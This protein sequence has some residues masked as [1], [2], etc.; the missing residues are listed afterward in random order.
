MSLVL[1]L[2]V[3]GSAPSCRGD[4]DHFATLADRSGAAV[5]ALTPA[6]GD[7]RSSWSGEAATAAD[8]RLLAVRDGLAAL[9]SSA[10]QARD[11]LRTFADQLD[12]VVDRMASVRARAV[13]AGL[14]VS[15]A[16][17]RLPSAPPD[18][19]PATSLLRFET[20]TGVFADLVDD[21][22]DARA[23]EL[24]AHAALVSSLESAT[25]DGAL[26]RLLQGAGL[27]P[28]DGSPAALAAFGL[29]GGLL[30]LGWG[31]AWSTS[32]TNGRFLPTGR[33]A[34]LNGYES[35]WFRPLWMGGNAIRAANP[36]NWVPAASSSSAFTQWR[37]AGTW[38]GRAGTAV[39]FGISAYDQWQEDADDPSMGTGERV[40]RSTTMGASTAAG[41]W[42]GA[43]AGTQVGATIGTAVGGPIGTV[44]GGAVGGIVGGVI[45]SGVGQAAGDWLVE[46][47]GPILSDIGGWTGDRWDDAG[48][49]LSDLGDAL[50]FWD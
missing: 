49:A 22:R 4:A 39:S 17:V 12:V 45:G 6:I 14:V 20:K 48:D 35:G 47:T 33:H 32:V 44:V 15:G 2:H 9:E 3:D 21:V 41:G 37:T 30:A 25:S 40:A 24:Q 23:V 19:A 18:D 42:A 31:S 7:L 43:W 16:T 10:G 1:D 28:T 29:S 13:A 8:S 36:D 46:N 27:L 26:V 38:A 34:A 5:D 11:T 50:T